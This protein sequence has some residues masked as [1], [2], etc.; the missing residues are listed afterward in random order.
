MTNFHPSDVGNGDSVSVLDV[1]KPRKKRSENARGALALS[2]LSRVLNIELKL[3]RS[4]RPSDRTLHRSPPHR[5]RERVLLFARETH[6]RSAFE[7][8]GRLTSRRRAHSFIF[9]QRER[10][11]RVCL[12]KTT[13][14]LLPPRGRR[15][16]QVRHAI[17]SSDVSISDSSLLLVCSEKYPQ[18]TALT[19]AR[20][21]AR[22]S[23]D[24]E[25]LSF[26]KQR[27]SRG[28]S[29][30][31]DPPSRLQSLCTWTD[32]FSNRHFPWNDRP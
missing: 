31:Y 30:S 2:L 10:L 29:I 24:V 3:A 12:L 19:R 18:I 27:R 9:Y 14:P 23:R 15:P 32:T 5:W 1:S 4:R 6:F 8:S 21:R 17:S 13:S 11:A 22:L 26:R 25:R 7:P 28:I 16:R 20:A